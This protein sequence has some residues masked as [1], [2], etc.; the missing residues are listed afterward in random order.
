MPQRGLVGSRAVVGT[1]FAILPPEG[2]PES[3]L[4]GWRAAAARILAAPAL[5]AGFVEY[6]IDLAPQGGA[7]QRMPPHVE[8]FL[9]AVS[10]EVVLTLEGRPN[11]LTAGGFAYL[12]PGSSFALGAIEPARLL[13]L[14]KVHQPLEGR[15]PWDVVGSES[16]LEGEPYL[17][18]GELLLKKLLPEDIAFDLA[19]NIFT[20]P[21]GFSLPI[22]ETHVMEHGLYM[23][24][25]Q[26]LYYL[27]R[28]WYEVKR[29]DFIWMG[30]YCPQSYY[31]TGSEPSRYI[32][33][34]NVHRD[35]DLPP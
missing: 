7:E 5:G 35:I 14:K 32:Y 30:P 22:T 34:K 13:W 16:A 27:G 23:L 1:R 25:G 29:G 18:I 9:Y 2:I 8:A 17:D 28:D 3:T 10:G 26:G 4:P 24:E 20:F 19:V 12:S 33:Y 6:L 31:A 11:R 15:R 21:P